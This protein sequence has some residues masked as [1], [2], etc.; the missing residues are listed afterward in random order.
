MNARRWLFT[1]DTDDQIIKSIRV[2][3]QTP[4]DDFAAGLISRWS[5]VSPFP[6]ASW[7]GNAFHII[8]LREANPR[9]S[10][11]HWS[12]MRSFGVDLN[13]M[14]NKHSCCRLFE[15][16]WHPYDATVRNFLQ[17]GNMYLYPKNY[18]I[19][20]EWLIC[21]S[22]A[23]IGS[24][25]GLSSGWRQAIIWTNAGILLFRNLGTNYSELL[26]EI[27]IFSFNIMQL[28]MSSVKWRPFCLGLK[29]LN[30]RFPFYPILALD[31][32]TCIVFSFPPGVYHCRLNCIANRLY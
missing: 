8:Y 32:L 17:C 12:V 2:W 23:T 13:R 22:V 7:Y 18:L 4:K 21:A 24:D 14:L 10:P 6:E 26:I 29:E 3:G 15:T 5:I 9:D 28:K 20:A 25:E 16:R 1:G 30:T 11:L 19:E 31:H 27:C